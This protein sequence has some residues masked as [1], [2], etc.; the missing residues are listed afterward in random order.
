MLPVYQGVFSKNSI[1]QSVQIG[2][3]TW[4]AKNA[5]VETYQNGDVIPEVTN[6]SAWNSLTTGA[7]CYYDNITANGTVYGK[8]YNWYAVHDPRKMAPV[9]WH[10]PADAEYAIIIVSTDVVPSTTRTSITSGIACI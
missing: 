7:W 3:Q 6:A 4:K 2:T 10:V 1:S 5:T 8:L 9:G